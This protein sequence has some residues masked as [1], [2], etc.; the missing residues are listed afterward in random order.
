[1]AVSARKAKVLVWTSMK[2]TGTHMLTSFLVFSAASLLHLHIPHLTKVWWHFIIIVTA[3]TV[4]VGYHYFTFQKCHV[5]FAVFSSDIIILGILWFRT[6]KSERL[7]ESDNT[8]RND[9][10]DT[11]MHCSCGWIFG[12]RRN[13]WR[14]K[15][16]HMGK[17][18]RGFTAIEAYKFL[19]VVSCTF[20]QLQ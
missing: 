19:T 9:V 5:A 13:E 8:L 1:M 11:F 20:C 7:I 12:T 6:K 18:D 16:M 15:M 10:P 2:M 17:T 3:V 14:R 4:A